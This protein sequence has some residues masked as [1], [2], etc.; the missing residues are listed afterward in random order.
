MDINKLQVFNVV[1]FRFSRIKNMSKLLVKMSDK[2]SFVG[3]N[4][5]DLSKHRPKYAID[6]IPKGNSVNIPVNDGFKGVRETDEHFF[7][8]K[9][10]YSNESVIFSLSQL[11]DSMKQH[12]LKLSVEEAEV[13]PPPTIEEMYEMSKLVG[14]E[15]FQPGRGAGRICRGCD[16]VMS[17]KACKISENITLERFND[18]IE[19][20]FLK[21]LDIE[22]GVVHKS[23]ITVVED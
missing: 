2:T 8:A 20:C 22:E 17:G 15:Q 23:S 1:R 19:Y 5:E 14:L 21:N 11:D 18:G 10:G 12:G 16:K 7:S 4:R 6:F 9:S 13:V 3:I